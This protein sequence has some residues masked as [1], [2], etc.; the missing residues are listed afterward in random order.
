[1]SRSSHLQQQRK[2]QDVTSAPS[3]TPPSLWPMSS[4][5]APRLLDDAGDDL[6]PGDNVLPS[7]PHSPPPPRGCEP[8]L[9]LA[10]ARQWIRWFSDFAPL[11]GGTAPPDA[12]LQAE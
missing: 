3:D 2:P 9:H 8:A 6:N 7:Y 12:I 11:Q 10:P 5:P 4:L 1:M